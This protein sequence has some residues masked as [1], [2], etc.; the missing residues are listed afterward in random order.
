METYLKSSGNQRG[1]P[2]CGAFVTWCLKQVGLAVPPGSGAARNWFP[3][4]K[5]IYSRGM[6]LRGPPKQGDCVGFYYANLGRIGH[7][8]FVDRWGEDFVITVEGNTGSGGINRNGDGVYRMR[9]LRSQITIV[10]SWI[11]E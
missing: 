5:V 4:A 7:V 10:S 3:A 8:G 11:P 1:Q 6:A 2:W 9:R